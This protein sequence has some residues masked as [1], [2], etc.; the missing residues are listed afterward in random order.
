MKYGP[1]IEID[2]IAVS[3]GSSQFTNVP[4]SPE[5]IQFLL[6]FVESMFE[7]NLVGEWFVFEIDHIVIR[8]TRLPYDLDMKSFQ[9]EVDMSSGSP[10]SA[11]KRKWREMRQS[12]ILSFFE[13]RAKREVGR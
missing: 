10:T 4:Y 13:Y 8:I 9:I 2:D 6:N 1:V 5:E 7:S 11:R 3:V 12:D